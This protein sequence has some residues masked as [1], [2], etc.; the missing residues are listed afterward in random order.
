MATFEIYF[1]AI[2]LGD[3]ATAW[4]L[5]IPA[6]RHPLDEWAAAMSTSFDL[7][8]V[9]QEVVPTAEGV[10]AWVTFTSLQMPHLGPRDGESCTMWSI[11]YRLVFADAGQ[12]LLAGGDGHDGGP[13]SW[14]C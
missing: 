2:N 8:V 6:Q 12:L 7:N 4:S 3:Y 5:S 14:P 1:A 11:D 9:V 13:I 10:D